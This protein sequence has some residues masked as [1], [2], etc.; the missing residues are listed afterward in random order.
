MEGKNDWKRKNNEV[1]RMK[2]NQTQTLFRGGYK[3]SQGDI[4]IEVD[5]EEA[6]SIG[7]INCESQWHK[8]Y[9]CAN[10]KIRGKYRMPKRMLH[11]Q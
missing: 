3:V 8:E 9:G 2:E 11:K 10:N 7:L 5:P 1:G 4:T 6:Y